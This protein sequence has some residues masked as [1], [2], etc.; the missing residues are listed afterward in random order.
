LVEETAEKGLEQVVKTGTKYL[1]EE[2]TEK[3]VQTGF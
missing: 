1:L 3:A 2:G